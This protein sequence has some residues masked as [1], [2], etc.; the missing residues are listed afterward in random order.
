M[1]DHNQFPKKQQDSTQDT[2]ELGGLKVEFFFTED[3]MLPG[4]LPDLI[5]ME[6]GIA[7]MR[8]EAAHM[9]PADR[10]GTEAAIAFLEELMRKEQ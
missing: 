7:E 9:L 3:G 2:T 4:E 6:Q 10:E 8:E 5:P 1:T